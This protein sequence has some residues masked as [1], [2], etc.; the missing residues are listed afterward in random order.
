MIWLTVSA[1]S[2]EV[3]SVV[4]TI[5]AFCP[6]PAIGLCW[7]V[8]RQSFPGHCRGVIVPSAQI[9]DKDSVRIDED[10]RRLSG[11]GPEVIVRAGECVGV[12]APRVSAP[13]NTPTA[14]SIR[15]KLSMQVTP[16][17]AAAR[18]PPATPQRS[19]QKRRHSAAVNVAFPVSSAQKLP[20]RHSSN[21]GSRGGMITATLGEG[22]GDASWLDDI[23]NPN[24]SNTDLLVGEEFTSPVLRLGPRGHVADFILEPDDVD[25]KLMAD[26]M[27]LFD[28]DGDD[29]TAIVGQALQRAITPEADEF[30]TDL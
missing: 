27:D 18:K 19:A 26:G 12:I 11:S 2:Q 21:G 3:Q 25:A 13:V 7:C 14:T 10:L 4:A 8:S 5:V 6:L 22:S 28:T 23:K 24:D 17:A 1:L 9:V 16:T 30:D 29:G 15:R 20:S